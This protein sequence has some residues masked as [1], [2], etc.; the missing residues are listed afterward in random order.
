MTRK[1]E[2]DR[3]RVLDAA[4]AVIVAT[5]GRQFTLDAV[6]EQADISKGGLVYSFPTKEE[7]L[8]AVLARETARF[9][10][11]IDERLG[12]DREDPRKR[13]LG[14]I[15]ELLAEDDVTRRRVSLL[16]AA[17]V[18][19]PSK[20]TAAHQ[21]YRELFSWFETATAHG[22]EVRTA[23]LAVEG[24]FLLRGLGIVDASTQD[25]IDVLENARETILKGMPPASDATRT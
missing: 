21:A 23:V 22:R 18:Q 1:K 17:L 2:I 25:W 24:L 20:D 4:A 15:E 5:G 8:S 16:F 3:E 13:L 9:F 11:A 14:Y 10:A 7:L 19:H 6:A 12:E